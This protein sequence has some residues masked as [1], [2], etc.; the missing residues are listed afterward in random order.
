L[1]AKV[2][3]ALSILLTVLFF[4]TVFSSCSIEKR[5]YRS[6]YYLGSA[7][8]HSTSAGFDESKER[9]ETS[10]ADHSSAR[11]ADT[12]L[13]DTLA[14]TGATHERGVESSAPTERS[15][16]KSTVK[17]Q[18]VSLKYSP[19]HKKLPS[20]IE[21]NKELATWFGVMAAIF[22]IG[23]ILTLIAFGIGGPLIFVTA[24]FFTCA[25]LCVIF[26]SLLYPKTKSEKESSEKVAHS[27]GA[28][29]VARLGALFLAGVF[30]VVVGLLALF[31]T[32]FF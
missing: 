15:Y 23:G 22:F 19:V 21:P 17:I 13:H 28:Q 16:N 20:P 32:A 9:V 24:L 27:E 3:T 12:A 10:V 25:V 5:H 30:L 31:L 8:S 4:S 26:A 2:N 18:P 11:I 7:R 14:C 1:K 29:N 6:G